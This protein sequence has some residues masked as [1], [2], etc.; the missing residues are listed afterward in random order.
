[1][2]PGLPVIL[3]CA[4]ADG[5]A[6]GTST[7]PTSILHGTGK[8]SIGAGQ[9]S[10]GDMIEA[11]IFGRISTYTS[12]TLTFDMRLGS[13][14]ISALGAI[15]PIV[16]LTNVSF[17]LLLRAVVRALGTGTSSNALVAGRFESSAAPGGSST[18]AGAVTLPMTAPAVGTG[19]DSTASQLV[20]IF[21]TWSVSNAA[22][23][24][25]V[26]QSLLCWYPG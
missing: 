4:V 15:T 12:G 21:G 3:A 24:L 23:V 7:T 6:Y 18:V 16:S 5:A 2:R 26:H 17:E 8:G 22:N 1:M 11:R 10:V 20:D 25:T 13:V 14:V 9:L 19:F